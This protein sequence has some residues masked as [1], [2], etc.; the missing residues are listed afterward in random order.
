MKNF[1][2]KVV[3]QIYPRSFQDTDGNGQGDIRGII[4]RLDYLQKLGV[5][6]IW[7]NPVFP[8]PQNDNG[9]DVADYRNI[10]PAFGTMEDVEELIQEA[11]KRGIGIMFDMVFNHTSTSHPWFRRALSGDP[12]YMD[13]YI[14]RKKPTNWQS[15]FGGSAWKKVE[16]LD[17]YYLHLFDETQADLNWKNPAVQ[18]EFANVV[19]FWK[20][21]GIQGFRFDVVNLMSKPDVY[22]DD[23]EGDGRR[24]YTDGPHMHEYLQYLHKNGFGDDALT[25]GEMSSTALKECVQYAGKDSEELSMVFSFHHLKTD[26]ANKEKWTL[27]PNDFLEMKKLLFDWQTG[28][29][30]HN[31]WNALFLNCHD[32]PRSVSR[33][34][35]D[36]KYRKESA[37]MLASISQLMRGTPYIYQGEEIG[38][39]NCGFS[40]IEQFRDVES[41]NAYD[42]LKDQGES[43]EQTIRILQAKSRDNART[44]M[45][46][47]ASENG[48][49][50]TGSPWIGVNP[51]HVEI[52][53]EKALKDPDSIFYYYQK[54]IQLR[55]QHPAISKGEIEPLL[56]EDPQ[57]FAWRR[58]Y[59]DEEFLILNNFSEEPANLKFSDLDNPDMYTVELGNYPNQAVCE[60]IQLRPWE[61]LILKKTQSI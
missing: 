24:F 45:Q 60:N 59:Q 25:V 30:D 27:M 55:K 5:D 54:L 14:F 53:V 1:E 18:K 37:K 48:G 56:E 29:Q 22:E 10:D 47:D 43:E 40:T 17:L 32:Q 52:N 11:G 46:W 39:T 15:K 34:G 26:Y 9:Y 44:P 51:N 28:M 58:K 42:I 33:Y 57:I 35:D 36:A 3:Y 2:D 6:M 31:S 61:S 20:N 50:T 21:K 23:L 41:L 8:S 4:S 49:F 38:M 7:M 16:D 13:R 12:E 19:R